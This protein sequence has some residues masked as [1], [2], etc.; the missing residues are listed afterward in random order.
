[1]R[2]WYMWHG[3][4]MVVGWGGTQT[5]IL[6]LRAPP[7]KGLGPCLVRVAKDSKN[8]LKCPKCEIILRPVRSI[9]IRQVHLKMFV[10]I[11]DRKKD[12]KT[13]IFSIE[14]YP[15]FSK[16]R[17]NLAVVQSVQ[18]LHSVHLLHSRLAI[19]CTA[20]KVMGVPTRTAV[21]CDSP[22]MHVTDSCRHT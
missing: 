7:L 1:M 9:P 10:W 14:R 19:P 22:C 13:F 21:L 18:S 17:E 3:Y 15:N 12:S 20:C 4:L 2:V 5:P 6:S 8:I 16:S 11:L